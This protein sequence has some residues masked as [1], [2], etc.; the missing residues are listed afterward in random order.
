MDAV[1]ISYALLVQ[2]NR[3]SGVQ[4]RLTPTRLPN[5]AVFSRVE[6]VWPIVALV[7]EHYQ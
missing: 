7:T 1:D 3:I 2:K 5:K 4:V 6:L